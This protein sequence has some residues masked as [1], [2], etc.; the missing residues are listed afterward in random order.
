[1]ILVM[2][3]TTVLL[4]KSFWDSISARDFSTYAEELHEEGG[5]MGY[6]G[7]NG[8]A[9]Y[10]AQFSTLLLALAAF[11]RKIW[12]RLVYYAVACYSLVCLTYSLSR[13]GYVAIMAG[14]LVIGVFKQRTLLIMLVLFLLVW[15][16]VV[17]GAV[18]QR[19]SSTYDETTGSFDN[20]SQT[21]LSLWTTALEVFK[22]NPLAGT[23]FNTYAL[24]NLNERTDGA[25]GYYRDT[26][27]YPIKVMVETGAIGLALFLWLLGTTWRT[28][29]HL[30]RRAKDPLLASL[31][32]GLIG[33]LACAVAANFF[34]DRWTF[35]Q[36]N[37]YMWVL[38]GLVSQATVLE[39]SP[40]P[41]RALPVEQA[42][43][44]GV[45]LSQPAPATSPHQ[46]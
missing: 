8:L 37:G 6:A 33:W 35:L 4:N 18:Q 27:N 5:T 39:S 15:T 43:P 46:F 7:A 22:E 21:R 38:A 12:L 13:A 3:F 28:G 45:Q 31:G 25:V 2:C 42:A 24:M 16:S 17:P 11:E 30:F 9:A 40:D 10:A 14:V 41:A 44:A 34:G 36:V 29:Y 1:M 20:S 23:G 19:V 32:L 26:H